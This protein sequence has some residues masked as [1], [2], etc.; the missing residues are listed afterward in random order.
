VPIV[1]FE[2]LHRL[3]AQ[4]HRR[5]D[6]ARVAVVGECG[7]IDA[8]RDV[9]VTVFGK[10][11]TAM[12]SASLGTSLV[13][14][15]L[16]YQQWWLDHQPDANGQNALDAFVNMLRISLFHQTF[17]AVE[18]SLRLILKSLAPSA[19]NSSAGEFKSVYECLLRSNLSHA[20]AAECDLLDLLR[21]V[22]NTIHNNGVYLPK[23]G[24]LETV[25]WKGVGYTFVPGTVI[26]FID[27]HF[28]VDRLDDVVLL[29]QTVVSDPAVSGFPQLIEDP[30]IAQTLLP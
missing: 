30:A 13:A 23:S 25:T 18:S 22:R 26:E 2:E 5:T 12:S 3:V 24:K 29:C 8:S 19:A 11:S 17:S 15:Y 27:W 16:Q 28:L 21:L 14:K 1:P 4:L 20:Y 10:L 6:A 7:S 9:R